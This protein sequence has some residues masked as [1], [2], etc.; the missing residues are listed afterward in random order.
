[1]KRYIKAAISDAN[2]IHTQFYAATYDKDP[3]VLSQLAEHPR[4]F[5]RSAVARN[6]NTPQD[7]LEKLVHDEYTEVRRSVL[8]NPSAPQSAKDFGLTEWKASG[9]VK[10]YLSGYF[11][12][13]T[14][15]NDALD[16]LDNEVREFVGK[17]PGV[18][19]LDSDFESI[20]EADEDGEDIYLKEL[21][22][23]CQFSSTPTPQLISKFRDALYANLELELPEFTIYECSWVILLAR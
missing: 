16:I 10:F 15:D 14:S 7:V 13:E 5:I 18:E 11:Y 22:F 21:K 4:P 23:D 6:S 17:V 3:R 1:M 8:T 20:V 9:K 19:Y 2:D 12:N